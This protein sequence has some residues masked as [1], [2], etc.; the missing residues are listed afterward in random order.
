[1]VEKRK[2]GGSGLLV[3]PLCLGGNV[4]G[5]TADEPMSHRILDAFLDNGFNFIDTANSYST[6]VPGHKGGESEAIIGNW[7]TRRGGREKVVIA[8]KVGS[9]MAPGRKGLAGSYIKEAVEESLSRLHTDYIDLY[10]SHWDDPA[11]PFEE[12]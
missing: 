8:T 3:A 9:E 1:M 2:L 4:F 5:W 10:Q 7:L 12:T 11:T 6:W